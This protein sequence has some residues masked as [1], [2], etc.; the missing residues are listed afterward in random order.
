MITIDKQNQDLWKQKDGW[1][2]MVTNQY[3][4]YMHVITARLVSHFSLKHNKCK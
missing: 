1:S 2:K 4:L 3:I